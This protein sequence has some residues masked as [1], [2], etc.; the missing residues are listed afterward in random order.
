M[1]PEF[2]GQVILRPTFAPRAGISHV[3]FDFDGDAV[4]DPSGLARGDGA[5]VHEVL[6][7]LPGETDADRG[8]LAFEDIMRRN[9]KQTI[10]QMC[11]SPR[12]SASW[13]ARPRNRSGTSTN[14]SAGSTFGS[15]T[16]STGCGRGRSRP[17]TCSF[18]G[19]VACWRTSKI[20]DC[21]STWPAE[22][23]RSLSS[24]RQSCWASPRYFGVRI[25]RR[26]G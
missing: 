21:R 4:A 14:T 7:A 2:T 16:G 1:E 15:R 3:L 13:A 19:L 25:L 20:A 11:N 22:P 18:M 6:P 26:P 24:K 10:Y 9:G 23:T 12:G 17:T 8:R 5:D